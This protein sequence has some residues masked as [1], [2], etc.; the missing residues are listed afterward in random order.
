MSADASSGKRILVVDDDEDGRNLVEY[1]L[2]DA[3]Y[4]V[5]SA[6]DGR[7]ALQKLSISRPD[8]VILDLMMP[9]VDG[10]A[11]L[12]QIQ[13]SAKP[14]KVVVLTARG[15]F[16]TVARGAREGAVAYLLKPFHFDVLVS[17]CSR[18]LGAAAP[19]TPASERRRTARRVFVVEVELPSPGGPPI[20]GQMTNIS[21]GGAQV[22]LR[23]PLGLASRVWLAFNIPG[24]TSALRLFGEVRWQASS[25]PGFAHGIA[26]VELS[27]DAQAKLKE[28]V[29]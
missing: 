24:G 6:V 9:H 26:F 8:L 19:V 13:A 27:E 17:T 25:P 10:W 12:E 3:G 18:L 22:D 28:L 21:L 4:A 7:E 29:S 15:D 5:D 2:Q 16:S 11:V 20:V 23:Q 14:P 1:V